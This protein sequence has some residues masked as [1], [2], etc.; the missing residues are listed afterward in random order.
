MPSPQLG[1]LN[2]FPTRTPSTMGLL[3][4][5]PDELK[6]A[7][8]SQWLAALGTGLLAGR[9]PQEGLALGF[10]GGSQAIDQANTDY[11]DNILRQ[12][13]MQKRQREEEDAATKKRAEEDWISQQDP[14]KQPAL[15]AAQATGSLDS[16]ISEGFKPHQLTSTTEYQ[17]NQQR[18]MWVDPY[19]GKPSGEPGQW[20]PRWQPQQ[21]QQ[22]SLTATVVDTNGNEVYATGPLKG[23]I[24]KLGAKPQEQW[25]DIIGPGGVTYKVN[26]S[27]QSN[28]QRPSGGTLSQ[29]EIAGQVAPGQPLVPRINQPAGG[30][31]IDL[32]QYQ[33]PD[34]SMPTATVQDADGTKRYA[35]GPLK[36]LVAEQPQAPKMQKATGPGGISFEY[37]PITKATTFPKPGGGFYSLDEVNIPGFNWN[38]FANKKEQASVSD[39]G[40]SETQF[41]AEEKIRDDFNQLPEVKNYKTVIPIIE[42]AYDTLGHDNHASDL[43]LIYALGKIMDPAS[44]VREGEMVMATQAGSPANQVLGYMSYLTGGGK[45][46]PELR[47][48]LVTELQSR[49]DALQQQYD[50]GYQRYSDI[51]KSYGLDVPRTIG[52]PSKQVTHNDPLGIR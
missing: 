44:V 22:L 37:D 34:S 33:K 45:F 8:L 7:R 47:Q 9:T 40:V 46:T 6:R 32:S 21:G 20:A 41:N 28:L 25:H 39:T 2:S 14:A 27:G 17:G 48:Q 38:K 1:L 50:Q 18:T 19:T 29:A 5:D 52:N 49:V 15:R 4:T 35:A 11:R 51:A 30:T 26:D 16:I 3:G 42:S 36:G 10:R 43:N 23:Q 24:A 12:Y 31:P 13:E